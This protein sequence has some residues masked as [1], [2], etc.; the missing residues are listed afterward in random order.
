MS[1]GYLILYYKNNMIESYIRNF[2]MTKYIS[3]NN[4][5]G[6]NNLISKIKYYHHNYFCFIN[7]E[8]NTVRC[9]IKLNKITNYEINLEI[10]SQQEISLQN[11]KQAEIFQSEREVIENFFNLDSNNNSNNTDNKINLLIK[12]SNNIYYEFICILLE[13]SF[14][15]GTFEKIKRYMKDQENIHNNEIQNN[16][17]HNSFIS[18]ILSYQAAFRKKNQENNNNKGINNTIGN[19]LSNDMIKDGEDKDTIFCDMKYDKYHLYD[20]LLIDKNDNN[21][22]FFPKTQLDKYNEL[23]NKYKEITKLAVTIFKIPFSEIDNMKEDIGKNSSN[24][25]DSSI[26][27]NNVKLDELNSS[28]NYASHKS[29]NNNWKDNDDLEMN[30]INSET[31]NNHIKLSRNSSYDSNNFNKG[32]NSNIDKQV[33]NLSIIKDDSANTHE[34]NDKNLHKKNN[35]NY[36]PN[37][38]KDIG[39]FNNYMN[40]NNINRDYNSNYKYYNSNNDNSNSKYSNRD[41]NINMGIQRKSSERQDRDSNQKR[42]TYNSPFY[43]NKS[44][45]YRNDKNSR[46]ERIDRYSNNYNYNLSNNSSFTSDR[47]RNYSRSRDGR[48]QMSSSNSIKSKIDSSPKKYDT[49]NERN[50]RN[51]SYKI[52]NNYYG[53]NNNINYFYN[54]NNYYRPITNRRND[55]NY[56][57][58]GGNY[59]RDNYQQNKNDYYINYEGHYNRERRRGNQNN[60]Y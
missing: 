47:G 28:N 6:S 12:E 54:I 20:E 9:I 42:N 39:S 52:S 3:L 43:K 34:M 53:N 5:I 46:N 14:D 41:S 51:T 31:N 18:N 10:K 13:N 4:A 33:N 27:K 16:L 29:K 30:K 26:N 17:R 8:K 38:K 58:Q 7:K 15:I 24:S 44:S 2:L 55:S 57:Y 19:N 45:N 11:M 36:I 37:Y 40:N 32:Y 35:D 60:N 59:Q 48:S 22:N 49:Y 1:T 56:H 23:G 25:R 21:D 50:D